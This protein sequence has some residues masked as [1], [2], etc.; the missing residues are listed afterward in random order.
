MNVAEIVRPVLQHEA[1]QLVLAT[2]E[3]L[4]HVTGDEDR[5]RWLQRSAIAETVGAVVSD[6]GI[7]ITASGP[8]VQVEEHGDLHQ[9]PAPFLR[10][11]LATRVE[12]LRQALVGALSQAI[13]DTLARRR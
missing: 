12:P 8:N 2:R 5:F 13:A 10:P 1:D 3:N 7:R 11:A 6:V 4:L 9:T